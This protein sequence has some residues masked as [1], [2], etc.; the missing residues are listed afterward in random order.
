MMINSPSLLSLSGWE[1]IGP[2]PPDAV[3]CCRDYSHLAGEDLQH[4]DPNHHVPFVPDATTMSTTLLFLVGDRCGCRR[5]RRTPCAYR[6]DLFYP[7]S[8]RHIRN[9]TT[10]WTATAVAIMMMSGLYRA[11][12][13]VH[14]KDEPTSVVPNSLLKDA[15]D[16][17]T[18][19]TDKGKEEERQQRLTI[20]SLLEGCRSGVVTAWQ[21]LVGESSR[22]QT[23]PPPT[24]LQRVLEERPTAAVEC[25]NHE[26]DGCPVETEVQQKHKEREEG[27]FASDTNVASPTSSTMYNDTT[28]ITTTYNDYLLQE[29]GT[30][31]SH[32][33]NPL[34]FSGAEEEEEE[35]EEDAIN[36]TPRVSILSSRVPLSEAS[37]H[38]PTTCAVLSEQKSSP[39]DPLRH[40]PL[41][42]PEPPNNIAAFPTFSFTEEDLDEVCVGMQH[43]TP[44][45]GPHLSPRS[46]SMSSA[47]TYCWMHSSFDAVERVAHGAQDLLRDTSLSCIDHTSS[48][49]AHY[50][51][52]Q[53]HEEFGRCKQQVNHQR[54]SSS[55]A[56]P[57]NDFLCVPCPLQ[58][59]LDHLSEKLTRQGRQPYSHHLSSPPPP[60]P[61]LRGADCCVMHHKEGDVP[62]RGIMNDWSS[63][64][65]EGSS[66]SSSSLSSS[67]S[68][69]ASS[70][71]SAHEDSIDDNGRE[72]N[73]E[74]PHSPSSPSPLPMKPHCVVLTRHNQQLL[75][76]ND[77]D[78]DDE[79]VPCRCRGG[80]LVLLYPIVAETWAEVESI[81]STIAGDFLVCSSITANASLTARTSA[82]QL[83]VSREHCQRPPQEDH[84]HLQQQQPLGEDACLTELCTWVGK[85]IAWMGRGILWVSLA[86]APSLL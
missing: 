9:T 41:S 38:E 49:P 60:P 29:S 55:R 70:F 12:M 40:L 85:A 3:P 86:P 57:A 37:T 48:V 77:D 11:S 22:A 15:H 14:G 79:K 25:I 1:V 69:C 82:T 24:S 23:H 67:F 78:D 5:T 33:H 73:N 56:A 35:K 34:E 4:L 6:N 72:P 10:G 47:A 46:A 42:S 51:P 32:R 13:D 43:F 61:P 7:S 65:D 21:W 76:H 58:T 84:H 27:K 54:Q 39:R 63:D 74:V 17:S 52:C 71:F 66:N 64:F 20:D 30:F 16:N 36:L 50:R 83:Q 31:S 75:L 53:Q 2:A 81:S 44:Q 18:D 8:Y 28:T 80:V 68:S 45:M 59:T 26:Q 62:T 19:S